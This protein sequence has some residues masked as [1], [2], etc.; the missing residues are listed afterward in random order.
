MR[1]HVSDVLFDLVFVNL[2]LPF[3]VTAFRGEHARLS[4]RLEAKHQGVS[5][6]STVSAGVA[7]EFPPCPSDSPGLFVDPFGLSLEPS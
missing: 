2:T 3:A 1:L 5:G 7:I 4:T 6:A